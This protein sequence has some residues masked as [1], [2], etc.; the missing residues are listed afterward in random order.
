MNILLEEPMIEFSFAEMCVYIYMFVY[1][2][3]IYSRLMG[4]TKIDLLIT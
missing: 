4:S 1:V 2:C 3:V